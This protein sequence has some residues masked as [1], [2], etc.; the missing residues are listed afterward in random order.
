[1]ASQP[2][3]PVIVIFSDSSEYHH[4]Q[5][6]VPSYLAGICRPTQL[7][8]NPRQPLKLRRANPCSIPPVNT[9]RARNEQKSLYGVVVAL[10]F[11]SSSLCKCKTC[12]IVLNVPSYT[13]YTWLQS[14]QIHSSCQFTP[15]PPNP[16]PPK[17]P[18]HSTTPTPTTTH[19]L[20][21]YSPPHQTDFKTLLIA[22]S[23]T[24]LLSSFTHPLSHIQTSLAKSFSFYTK[25]S[26]SNIHTLFETENPT[27]SQISKFRSQVV[28]IST[29]S[30]SLTRNANQFFEQ[31]KARG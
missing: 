27:L 17:H 18:V 12:T 2:A 10:K 6:H 4:R 3:R 8:A 15:N 11:T 16:P 14:T 30:H 29:H 28:P 13:W 25:A 19:P 7:A 5:I 9:L 22:P 31:Q 1:V 26:Q 23:H 20:S 24:P 21:R